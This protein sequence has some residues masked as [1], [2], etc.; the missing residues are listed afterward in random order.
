MGQLVRVL[1]GIFSARPKEFGQLAA[2]PELYFV[3][4]TLRHAT[5]K[6]LA[7]VVSHEA[8][9]EGARE[10][11]LMRW[12]TLSPDG[13]WKIFKASDSLTLDAHQRTPVIRTL[14]PELE[15]L[16]IH[17]LWPPE[18]MAEKLA[19]GWTPERDEVWR[20]ERIRARQQQEKNASVAGNVLEEIHAPALSIFSH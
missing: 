16:S 14:S 19:M 15:K 17:A 5:K 1:P 2:G 8:V 13:G 9:P 6:G 3:F 10:Y 18:V 20:R 7:Q 4:Y 12:R 11:P